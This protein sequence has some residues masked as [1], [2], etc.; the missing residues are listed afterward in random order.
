MQI[1]LFHLVK[2]SEWP[3]LS[4]L[5]AFLFT[6]GLAFHTHRIGGGR[7]ILALGALLSITVAS[8][9]FYDSVSEASFKGEHTLVVR[10]NLKIG[11]LLFSVSEI[12]LFS[13]FL[14]ASFHSA[15]HPSVE[16]MLNW[17]P[18]GIIPIYAFYHPS[19]NTIIL[20][21]SGFAVTLIH[22]SISLGSFKYALDGLILL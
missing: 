22:K 9:W 12:M 20:I 11:F 10:T 19:L 17:P 15:L 3:I 14:R 18:K 1:H 4:A 6:S 21:V 2:P 8:H 7:F 16:F 5:G 13:G